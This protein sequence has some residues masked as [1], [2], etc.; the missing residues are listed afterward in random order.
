[1]GLNKATSQLWI[2]VGLNMN[3]KRE[4]RNRKWPSTYFLESSRNPEWRVESAGVSWSVKVARIKDLLGLL[5]TLG[6]GWFVRIWQFVLDMFG[7]ECELY[8]RKVWSNTLSSMCEWVQ[9]FKPW[10][11][12]FFFFFFFFL[13]LLC[14]HLRL[15]A[16]NTAW[17][18]YKPLNRWTT[19]PRHSITHAMNVIP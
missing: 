8:Q 7:W 6:L 5:M 10:V 13:S 12:L 14:H 4:Q 9:S 3:W 15:C 19:Q 1:M 18:S 11:Q 17:G 2:S 16:I